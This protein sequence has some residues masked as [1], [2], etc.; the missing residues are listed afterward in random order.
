[1]TT[2][3]SRQKKAADSKPIGRPRLFSS[4]IEFDSIVDAYILKCQNP[5]KPIA[6]TLT[7]MVLALGF[8]SKD[9]FYEYQKYPEFTD[10]V[11]RARLLI[12]QEYENRLLSSSNAAASIFALKNF[13]WADKHPSYLD[14]LQAKKLERE[15]QLDDEPVQ[16]ATVIF[17]VKDAS[18]P[19]T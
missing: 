16:P 7:G 14:D 12:E 9:T 8:C 15:L 11:K 5:D 4:P 19:K 2:K 1:M 3:K 10:S 13:G 18:K 6:I 17:G